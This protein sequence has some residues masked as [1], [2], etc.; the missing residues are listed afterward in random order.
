MT[1]IKTHDLNESS[2]TMKIKA[3]TLAVATAITLSACGSSGGGGVDTGSTEHG[4]SSGGN[5]GGNNTGGNNG[6]NEPIATGSYKSEAE[7][8]NK[9]LT[10]KGVK[11]GLN[12][13]GIDLKNPGLKDKDIS[14][15]MITN[16]KNWELERVATKDNNAIYHGTAMAQIIYKYAPKATI[17]G[18]DILS[19]GG[20][21]AMYDAA[22]KMADEDKISIMNHSWSPATNMS[23]ATVESFAKKGSAIEKAINEKNLLVF[24]STGNDGKADAAVTTLLPKFNASLKKGFI[25]VAATDYEGSTKFL[26]EFNACGQ[27][28]DWCVTAP[29]Y[30]YVYENDYKLGY[31]SGTS[32]ATAYST[33]VAALVKEKYGWMTNENLKDVILGTATDAGAAGID[34]VYGWGVINKS[35]AIKGYG[36][37]SWGQT[38]LNVTDGNAYFDNNIFGTG[39]FN[40]TGNGQLVLN[41]DNTYTGTSNVNGGS[42]VVNGTNKSSFNVASGAKLVVGD[43]TKISTGNVVNNGT[44]VSETATDLDINGNYTQSKGGK[45]QKY[46]GSKLNVSGVANLNGALELTGVVD[47][48]VT[49]TNQNSDVI[50]TA[51]GGVVNQF[52]SASSKNGLLLGKVN[53]TNNDVSVNVTRGTVA[54]A[55]KQEEGFGNKVAI[56]S[57]MDEVLS[58]LDEIHQTTGLTEEQKRV[59]DELLATSSTKALN[60][61]LFKLD[62]SLYSKSLYDANID[63]LS[64]DKN[65]VKNAQNGDAAWINNKYSHS[66]SKLSGTDVTRKNN[67]I[68]VGAAKGLGDVT[69]GGQL[70]IKN[71]EWKDKF[72]SDTNNVETDGVGVSISVNKKFENNVNVFGVVGL[73]KLNVEIEKDVKHKLDSKQYSV[74]IG[75]DKTF[76]FDKLFVTP[77]VMVQYIKIDGD[78]I[79]GVVKDVETNQTVATFSV[80]VGYKFT[81]KLKMFAEVGVE[82]DVTQSSKYTSIRGGVEVQN[83]LALPDTR[84]VAKVGLEYQPKENITV[85]AVYEYDG[86]S[87]IHTNSGSVFLKYTF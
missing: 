2:Q 64:S 9:S 53:Y 74:G 20:I 29:A 66:S 34:N 81:K 26:N 31:T 38:A 47:G 83:E 37:F 59:Y 1:K 86:S 16:N 22:L 13:S 11:V 50:L 82:H 28:K 44:L 25:A 15:T 48:Y 75:A 55:V 30:Q 24:Q 70:N 39:G 4:G 6:G 52:T 85:G 78:N 40:K 17:Y 71:L 57:E 58:V 51:K 3:I 12:D 62:N 8:I 76:V 5:T 7:K 21:G 61:K 63:Q 35:K 32:N 23:E 36:Q 67:T 45:L 69:V 33:G 60:S 41:G 46:V 49:A 42:V 19:T 27:A 80:K 68:E 65:L 84:G 18:T 43:N 73:A 14:K 77:T 87:K 10:G 72:G 54:N 79:E 56:A